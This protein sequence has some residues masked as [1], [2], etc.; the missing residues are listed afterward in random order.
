MKSIIR[1]VLVTSGLGALCL[2]ASHDEDWPVREQETIQK[3]LNLSGDPMRLVVDNISGYVH[4]IG[5]NG[6]TVQVTAHKAIRAE[7]D[8]DLRQAK[9]EVKLD[10]TEQPGSV[11]IYYAA[12]WRCD[13]GCRGCCD[14]CCRD[15]RHFYEVTYDIDVTVPRA[16]RPVVSTV[17][18]GDILINGAAGDF[19]VRDVN[20]SIEMNAIGGSGDIRTVNGHVIV[21]FA[22]N[23]TGPSSFKSVNGSLDAYFPQ[24]L[25]AN[26]F[27]KTFNGQ[28]FSDF[29]V[30]PAAVA[31]AVVEKRD[32]KFIYRSNRQRGGLAGNGGPELSFDTLNGDVR[33]HRER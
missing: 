5:G 11:T 26:L 8:A 30:A 10:M 6:S 29:E 9:S 24:D 20:G 12:P 32:G 28:I 15:Q 25:S 27:F 13:N 23:P 17:N 22:K 7:S 16:A 31:S 33:L 1:L 19:D 4:V 21:H 14:G 18:R 2:A 3:S